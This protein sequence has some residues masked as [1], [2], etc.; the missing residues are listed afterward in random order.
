MMTRFD[1]VVL[2][3]TVGVLSAC[4]GALFLVAPPAAQSKELAS[5]PTAQGG[6]G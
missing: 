1:H 3:A 4:A 2:L 6:A 5:T